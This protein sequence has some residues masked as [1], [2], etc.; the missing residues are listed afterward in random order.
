MSGEEGKTYAI[1]RFVE[2]IDQVFRR[3]R[4]GTATGADRAMLADMRHGF[5]EVS[6]S[7]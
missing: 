6:S 3:T 7:L 5:S 1:D 4:D 2:M